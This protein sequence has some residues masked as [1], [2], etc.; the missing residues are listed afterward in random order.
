VGVP[1][2][3]SGHTHSS[4]IEIVALDAVGGSGDER[5]ALAVVAGTAISSRTRRTANAYNLVDLNGSMEAGA[6]VTVQV[7]E[8]DGSGWSSRQ[9]VRF[10]FG[11]RGM[12]ASVA[13]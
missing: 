8:P 3:L 6:I 2:L 10:E 13:N 1:V 12:V 5:S 9:T 4:S 7:R 11:E